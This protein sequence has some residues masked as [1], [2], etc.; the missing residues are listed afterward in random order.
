MATALNDAVARRL[1]GV[2]PASAIRFKLRKQRPLLWTEPRTARWRET[3][4]RP[5]VSMVWSPEMTG[6]FLDAAEADRLSPLYHLAAYWGLRR[7]EL[8]GLEWADVDLGHRRIHVRQAQSAGELDST[9]SEDSD[10]VI[11]IDPG[12]AGVLKQWRD[13]Q[14]FEAIEWGTGWGNSGRVFTREDGQPLRP[15]FIS[16]HFGIL[17]REAGLPPITFHDLRHGSASLLIAAGVDLKTVSQILGHSTVAFTA[18][19]YAVVAEELEEAAAAA[20][21]AIVPRK[22]AKA[23]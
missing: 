23:A 10:R 13:T 12:T 14:A 9:K 22:R 8:A 15:A 7:G 6:A 4:T 17:A 1:I 11:T 5:A 19:V 2:S 18:D 16:E 21:E 20:I 3:G